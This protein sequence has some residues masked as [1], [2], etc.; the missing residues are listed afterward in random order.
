MCFDTKDGRRFAYEFGGM[1][2]ARNGRVC[3]GAM[4]E[5]NNFSDCD[6]LRVFHVNRNQDS[7]SKDAVVKL[8]QY[9]F[10]VLSANS[11]RV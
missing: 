2:G 4:G 8:R 11:Y 3:G 9:S 5:P 7:R 6:C 1:L 10:I